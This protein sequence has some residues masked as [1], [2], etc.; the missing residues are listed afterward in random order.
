[1][2][3]FGVE[4][5][6]AKHRIEPGKPMPEFAS[7]RGVR[8][9]YCTEPNSTDSINS[10]I[11]KDLTG[12]EVIKY[13]KLYS[14]D[15]QKFRPM[16]KIHL[17]CNDSPEVDGT[18]NGVKRRLV[19]VDYI[20]KFVDASEVNRA[21]HKYLRDSDL[22]EAFKDSVG[23]RMAFI[24]VLLRLYN[25]AWAFE[26]PISV[27]ESSRMFIEDNDAVSNFVKECMA[28]ETGAWFTLAQAKESFKLSEHYNN[29]LRTLKTDLQK[30]LGVQCLEQKW[31]NGGSSK[32]VFMDFRL[33][34]PKLTSMVG[35]Q[36]AEDRLDRTDIIE[37]VQCVVP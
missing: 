33:S 27:R 29:K 31:L 35:V 30:A 23:V 21:E 11:M 6:T 2:C 24:R 1:M 16:Y 18:D 4:M 20:S 15:M 10:G 17:M 22:I 7:W 32:R 3:K 12:G 13:R 25:H 9:L 26:Q 34:M 14:N 28:H 5:L 19:K 8:Y 36:Q 37:A